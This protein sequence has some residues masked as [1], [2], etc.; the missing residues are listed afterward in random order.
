MFFKVTK[1]F[2]IL[3]ITLGFNTI[4]RA[5]I[6]AYDP[7]I[8][9]NT[10]GPFSM[11][12]HKP[13]YVLPFNFN[14]RIQNYTVYQDED[15][16]SPA[17]RTEIK[18]QVSFKVPVFSG[19]G[20]FPLS[21]YIA[22]TQ[23]SFWQAYNTDF[24]SPFRETNYEP[25]VFLSWKPYNEYRFIGTDWVFKRIST[26]LVHQSN[27]L[28]EPESRSWNRSYITMMFENNNFYIEGK[29]WHRLDDSEDNNPDILD[30]YGQGTISLAYANNDH[31]FTITSRNNIESKLKQGS[32]SVSWSFPLGGNFRGYIQ[33]F[34][35]YGNSLIE[36]NVYTNTIGVGI[37]VADFL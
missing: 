2:I 26:G 37:S 9:E 5:E 11:L 22:Y 4:A 6:S 35:G 12:P 7:A 34:S 33:G 8:I 27:G 1:I 29:Y 25:E 24:S 21:A 10:T 23:V 13:T 18:Y 19:V 31:T 16:I 15:G 14:D 36:Y 17:Q 32:V 20:D 3:A 28:S 30:Y